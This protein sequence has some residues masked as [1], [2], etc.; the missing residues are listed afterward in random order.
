MSRF[1]LVR[2]GEIALKGRNRPVFERSLV[3]NINRALESAGGRPGGRGL[4]VRSMP[5]RLAVQLPPQAGEAE[6]W[7][8]AGA[9]ARVFGV[10][11]VA[12][13][14]RVGLDQDEIARAAVGLAGEAVAGEGVRT[15]KLEVRRSNKAYPLT[16]PEVAADI[17]RRVIDAVPELSVDLHDPDLRIGVEVREDGTYVYGRSLPGPGGL[18]VGMSGRAVAL[19]SGGIDSPVAIWMAMRR[20]VVTVPLHFWSFP[21]TSERA[22]QKVIDLCAVLDTWGPVPD[23]LVCPFTEI[24]TAVRDGCP[25]EL[26]VTVMRRMMMRVATRVAREERALALVTGESLG[27]VASQTLESLASIEAA[28]GFPVLRPLL[29]LDKEEI[30]ARARQI[31]TY[32]ISTLPYEDCC[33]LFVP[34]HP[35]TRPSRREAEAAEAGLDVDG[36][37]ERAV[38]GIER[39]PATR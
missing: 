22:R 31:G 12:P 37:V 26:R 6:V 23:L 15:F 3:H 7:R 8:L 16:S 30:I 11:G 28:S 14:L 33:T 25:E 24:Q 4:R 1:L 10:V 19:I 13:A 35:R 34:D 17:G 36:L 27:Q 39:V 21:F 5:G 20:G 29:A 18:P 9:V 2:Y 38:A 32:D